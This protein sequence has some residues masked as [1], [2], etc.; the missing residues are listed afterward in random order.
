MT[1]NFDPDQWYENEYAA[2]DMQHQ[3]GE[4]DEAAFEAAIQALVQR[5]EE[6]VQ[7][8]DGT[9]QLARTNHEHTG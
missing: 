7:R 9:F 5:Y 2:L 4:L 6:M 3:Q 8:L 1:Y